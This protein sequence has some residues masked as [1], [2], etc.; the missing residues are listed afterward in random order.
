MHSF[1]LGIL[2]MDFTESIVEIFALQKARL[3]ASGVSPFQMDQAEQKLVEESL[4]PESIDKQ[5]CAELLVLLNKRYDSMEPM[6]TRLNKYGWSTANIKNH[7]DS[8]L[9][10]LIRK[11]Q[12]IVRSFCD[13]ED[14]LAGHNL[15]HEGPQLAPGQKRMASSLDNLCLD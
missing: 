8:Y 5:C 14:R 3:L 6:S 1:L 11:A 2:E 10:G 7:M 12:T 4:D 9:R 13:S 15:G